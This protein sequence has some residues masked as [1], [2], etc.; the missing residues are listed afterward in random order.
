MGLQLVEGALDLPPLRVGDSELD[1]GGFDRIEECGEQP[2]RRVVDAAVVELIVDYPDRYR[3]SDTSGVAG[4][5][6]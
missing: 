2:I 3:R 4:G 1:C 6:G 5:R